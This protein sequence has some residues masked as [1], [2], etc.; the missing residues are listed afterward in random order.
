MPSARDSSSSKE[1]R[2]AAL[3]AHLQE[4]LRRRLAGQATQS[5]TIPPADRTEPLPLSFSQQRLWF[6]NEFHAGGPQPGSV[7]YNS[8]LALRL[9]GRLQVPALIAAMRELVAR[10]E[11]LRTTFD[12]VDGTGIQVVH[13]SV[14][15]PVPV[16]E[17]TGATAPTDAALDAVL[18]AEYGRPF[19]LRRG[20][21]FRALLVRIA[22]GDDGEHVLLLAAH[23]IVTDGASM[24]VLVEE[25]GALYAAAQ[26]GRQ[27]ELPPL[28]VQ[29]ADFASWQRDRLSG[30]ALAGDLDYWTRQL[31]GISRLELPVDR[32]RP[33]VR[34]S[35]G[36]VQEFTVPAEVAARLGELARA[37][38]TTLFTVL[39]AACQVL[40]ARWSGQDDIAVGTV[41]SGRNR[42]ELERLVG[43]FVNTL[44]LRAPVDRTQTFTEFLGTV[45]DT[46]LD[47]FAHQEVPFERL[48]DAV[49][50]ERDAS[51][52]PLFDVMVLLTSQQ[53]GA[54]S[55]AELRVETV[56]ISGHTAIF[57][58]TCEFQLV[59]TG[60][61]RGVWT[62]NTD[63]FDRGTVERMVEQ[64]SV[65]LAAVVTD[66]G[67]Q[68]GRLPLLAAQER[69]RVLTQWNDT[70]RVVPAATLP[71]VFAA[72]VARTPQAAAVISEAGTLS[73]PQL[74]ER[75]NRLARVLIAHGAGPER[76]VALALP[77]SVDIVVA[78]L[79]VVTA[80]A[81]FVPIDP[82][83]P[84][85]RIDFM[86]AD[87]DPVVVLT[88]AEYVGRLRRGAGNAEIVVL[89]DPD[90][91]AQLAA[92]DATAVG[93]EHRAGP[94]LL[95]HPAYVIYTSGSSGRPKAVVVTHAGL[96][97]FAAAQT[98]HFGV[99]P[100]DRV[101]QFSSPSFD[102]SV[103]ELCLAL[104][105]GAA[106]V[107]PPPGRLLAEQLADV[108]ESQRIS[109]ALIPPAALATLPPSAARELPA[110]RCLIV[111]GEA[112]L[113]ELVARWAPGRTMINAYGPTESTVVAA[114]SRPL[115]AGGP[116]PIGTPI[117]NTQL[118][119]LDQAL[120]PVPV[121]VTGELYI[122]GAGLAR[123]YLNRP[124][125]TAARFIANPFPPP[126]LPPHPH[127][128]LDADC[129]N[130][131]PDYRVLHPE[132]G[133][134]GT[135]M[136]RSGDL[137]RWNVGGWLEFVGRADEQVKI[138]GYRIELGEVESALL[139]HPD[140]AAAVV[141]LVSHDGR[142]YLLA[143][144]VAA[145]SAS[146]PTIEALREF[147]GRTLPDYMLPS[148]VT[149]LPALPLTPSGKIDRRALPTP[150]HRPALTSDYVAPGTPIQRRLADIWAEVLGGG[151][152]VGVGR[153][154]LHDN[155]FELGGDSILSLQVV[156][157][158]RQAGLRLR[159][160]DIFLH[161]TIAALAP[162][163]DTPDT[164]VEPA[165]PVDG[166]AP[167]TPIQRWFFST[168]GA[169]SHFTMSM[170]VELAE[171]LDE[172]ALQ[173]AVETVVARHDAL[174]LRF[175]QVDGQ[176]WQ[177][178]V[179]AVASGVLEHHDL[180]GLAESQQQAAV[181][182]AAAAARSDLDLG[183]GRMIRAVL[184]GRGAGQRA[185]LFL[186][187]H[188]L[189][190]DGVSWRILLDDLDTAYRQ[191]AAGAAVALDHPG[192]S[193]A[194]WAHRLAEHVES[195]ALDGELEYWTQVSRGAQADLPVDRAGGHTAGSTRRVTGR[196]GRAQTEALLH[197]VPGVYRTQINDVLLSALGRVLSGWTGRERV[198]VTL[199]GHG[200]EEILDGVDLS[201]SV[202]W[203]T[204]QFPVA[205]TVPADPDWRTVVMS[206]KEQLR[207][208]PHRGLSY[209][210]LQ[211]LSREDSPAAAL[212]CDPQPQISFNY[213]GQWDANVTADGLFRAGCDGVGADLA[214]EALT[215][216]L[217]EVTGLV[218]A[219]E[220]AL[221]WSYSEQVHDQAT[222]RRLAEEMIQALRDIV[223]HCAQP[224]AGGRTPSDFPLAHLDQAGVDR[225]VG[226]GQSI[227]D[228]H[229]LTP[230][231]AGI[232]FHSLVD[233]DSGAYVDQARLL[234]D[235]VSDPY[236]LGTAWQR[237][238]D[239]TPTLRSAVV[240]DGVDEP[241]QVVHRHAAVP[242]S[243][244]DWRGLSDVERDRELA[245]VLAADRAA[246]MDLAAPP[247]LRLAIATLAD[248]QVLLVCTSHHV[249]LDGWSL[250]QVFTEVRE[251]YAAIVADRA[252][253]LVT[254]RPFR[255]YLQW[256]GE[257]DE[258]QA[259]E[260]WRRVLSGF[261]APTGLPYDRQPLEAHRAESAETVRVELSVEESQRLQLVAKRGG[262]TLNTI[263]Q[264]VWAVLLSRYTG[265]PD[266]VFGTTVSGRPA[267]LAG[268]ESMV[269]MFINTVPTRVHVP[270]GPVPSATSP[271]TANVLS[272]LREL[273]AAQIESR[274][275][276]F[277]SLAQ[278]QACSDLPAG[279]NLFDSMVVFENYPF[280]D[281]PEGQPGLRIREVQAQD[282][283]NFPL[284][285]R[286]YLD[287]QLGVDLGYD[288]RLFD[289]ATVTAMAQ[290]LR[291]LL[292]GIAEQ[293]QRPVSELPWMTAQERHRV[294]LDWNDTAAE[295][296]AGTVVELFEAQVSRTPG[297]TAVRCGGESLSYAEL[298]AR[299]NRLARVLI[300]RGVG[301]E[302]FVALMV[303]RSVD[304]VVALWAVWKAGAAYLPIDPGYPAERIAFMFSDARPVLVVTTSEV[305]NRLPDAGQAIARLRLDDAEVTAATGADSNGADLTDADR[306][307][308]L[309][310]A[311]AA[312]LIYTSGSTGRPKGVVVA[313]R[314][315]VDLAV[316]A[317]SDFG[318]A[319]LSRVVAS[320]SLNFDVSVFEIFCPLTVG[321]C[322]EMVRDVL[323]LAESR[324]DA[325]VA[326]LISGVPSALS[327]V[328][329]Q[330]RV[331]A[332][333]VV[334]AGEALSARAVREIGSATSCR[335]IANIYGPTEA[336][337][338]ATAWYG[339]VGSSDGDAAGGDQAPPI[340]RPIANTQV[341]VLDAGLRPVPIGVPGELYLAGHGLARGYLDRPG[342]TAQRFVAN[343]FGA[344]G[345]RMYRTG[346]VVRW[347]AAGELEY[348]GRVDHQVK[349]RGFRIELGEI[350]AVLAGHPDVAQ[351][352]VIARKEASAETT[353]SGSQRLVAYLVASGP[354]T[355][356]TA[357]LRSFLGALLPDYMVPAA[358][359]VLAE[360]PLN[361]S[362]K[363]DRRALPAPEWGGGD[364][365]AHVAPRT[366]AERV[367]A[368]IWAEVL[369]VEHVGVE[370]NFFEL[371]GDSILSIRVASRLRAAFDVEL[372]PRAVFT[373]S[374]VGELAAAIPAGAGGVS[375][376][377][378]VRRDGEPAPF[379]AQ[380]SFA[381]QRLWF[382][383]EFEPDSAEYATRV[384]L[385]LR[386]ELDLDALGA[387]FTGL[388]A[389]HESLRTTFE[390][391]DGR[392]MQVVHPPHQVSLPVLDLSGLAQ[393]QL[394][395][396]QRAAE[397]DRV[398]A[399]ESSRPF[400]LS[401]GPLMR[402]RLVRLGAQD[403][404]L[405]LVLHHIITDG[406]SM[407]VLVEELSALY[408]A[409][410]RHE[411]AD[412]APL[413]VQYADF[414]AWQ[415]AA[416][417]GPVLDE[418]LAYWRGQL[419]GVPPLELPTDRPRPAIRTSAGA[420][421]EFVVSAEVTAG[422]KELGRQQDGTLF[423]TL[424][425]ACQ[426]LFSRWSGQDDIAVGTVVSGRERTELEGLIGFF[427]NTLVLRSR[428]DSS[429]S[430]TQF[431]SGVR[432]T[433]L[434]ALAHQDVP[435]ERLVD[436]LAPVRDTSRPPLF[437]AMVILQNNGNQAPD[438]PGLQ[439]EDLALPMT[440]ASFDITLE[441]QERDDVLFGA[442]QYNTDLFDAATV[443]AMAQRFVVLLAGIAAD[444][445]CAVSGLPW[446]SAD[447][448]HRVLVEWNGGMGEEPGVTL[449]E[450]F[451]SQVVR[452]PLAVA[453]RC[454]D[455]DLSYGELNARANRLAR[456]LV[457]RG[458]G[459]ERLVAL[460]LPRSLE[461]VVAI[462]AVLKAGAG[463]LPLDPDLPA[464][465]IGRIVRDADP[466]L[467]ITTNGVLVGLPAVGDAVPVL[468]LDAVADAAV[469]ARQPAGDLTD[470]QRLGCVSPVNVAYAIYTSGSTGVPKGVVVSHRN[471]VRLFSA[472]RPWFEFDERDVWTLFHSY[473]FDV[474]VWEIWGALLHGGRLVVVPFAVSRSPEEFL[475][476]LVA[477]R[478]TVLS[479]TPSA[480]YPLLRADGEHPELGAQTT[481]RYVVF[482]GE[483]L[484][485]WR[486]AP[487]YERHSDTAPVLV[488]MYG[489][490]ETTVHTTYLA[491]DAVTAAE[492]TASLIGVGIP[493]LRVYVLDARLCPVP[494]GVVGEMYVGGAA[495]T[496][497]YLN[498]PG[499]T[500]QRFV[501]DPFGAPGTRMYR[502]GDLARW[503]RDG[504][505]EFLGRADH[506]VKIRGF[507]IEPGEIEAVLVGHP[508]VAQ[509]VVIA[510]ETASTE[511]DGSGGQRLVAYVVTAGSDTHPT[512]ELRSF[513]S[514]RLPD[515]MVPAAFVLLPELP[516][517]ANGKLDRRA[518]PA[519]EW[520]AG[521]TAEYIAPRTEAEHT[522]AGI[523][524]QVLGVER[525]GVT[526]N[527]F[528]LGGDSILSIQV[529]SRVRVVFGVE[530][531]PRVLF[532]DPTV[533]G[534]AVAVAESVVSA[535]ASIGVVD[536]VGELPLSF[537]QSFAQQ[538][539]WFLDEF[540]PGGSG[541]VSAFA[542]RLCGGLDVGALSVALTGLVARHESLRTTFGAVDGRGV[543]VVHPPSVVSLPVVDLSGLVEGE[544]DAE[545]RR[546]VGL[547][548]GRGFDLGRGPLLRVLLVRVGA[549]E[550][551]LSVA[552][553]HIVTD[554]W[555]MGVLLG[556][557][558]V[559]YSAGVRG[560]DAEL[561]V[562]GVQYVD[563]AVWQRELLSGPVL[564]TALGYWREQLAGV[565]ALELPTDR[566]RPA[567]LTSAGAVCEFVV[568]AGVLAGL[569]GLG[570][571]VDG[572]LFMTLVAACQVL[573]S[574]W[575][576][577]ADIAVGTVV[578][579]R[580]RA[581]LEGLIGFFVNTVVLRFRV[582]GQ[583]SFLEFLA[584]V[585]E[586]VLDAFVHQHVPF[587][588]VV[589]EL[590]PV[591][592]TSRTPLFQAMVV[593]QNAPGH[594]T[595]LAGLEVS[596]LDLPVTTTN[597]DVTVQ[598]H[599]SG[600][601]LYGALQYNTDL[602]D[603]ATMARM[604][605]HLVVLLTGIAADPDRP[606]WGLPVLTDTETH[607]VLVGW[608][609]THREVAG[610]G[611][612]ELFEA[613]VAA[614]PEA[615]AVRAGAV[616]L[617][618]AQ[619]DERANR[620][621]HWLIGVG[622]GPERLVAVALP[623][624]V[625]LV[626]VLLAV[627]K[628]GGGYLPVDPDYPQ[629]RIAF[630][631]ADSAPV[632]VLTCAAVG[633]QVPVSAGAVRVVIDDPVVAA[634]VAA[635]PG[636][637]PTDADR[638]S[639]LALSHPAYVIYTSGSTGRPKAVVVT[640]AGLSSFSAAEI[641]HYRVGPG[642][643]VLAM[644]SPSFD[645]S[646]LELGISLLAG[647]VWVLPSVAGP[648]AGD[649]L[650][651]VLA[652]DRISHALIPPAALATLPAQVAE[653]GLPEFTTVIVGGDVCSAEL[654]T[655]WAPNRR[656]INSYGPTE[657]TVVA[658]W[659]APLVAGPT[660]PV[661]G[662]P[663]PNTRIYVLDRWLR[664]VPVGVTG[665][666]Y[667]AG[668][669]LARGY[670]HR[671]GLTAARFVATPYGAPGERMYRSGDL[672]R[673]TPH[674]QLDYLGRADQQI[675]IR[676]FRIEPGEIEAVLATHPT[677]S[678]VAVTAHQDQPGTTRLVAYV[679]P[680]GEI[681]ATATELRTHTAGF[682][683]DYMIPTI[684]ITLDQIP[685]TA[686]GKLDRK[687][688]PTPD[689]HTQPATEH[690]PPRTPTEHTLAD[691]WAQ[692]LG[693]ERV[694]VTDNFF[695]LGG[696]SILSIQVMSRVRVVFGVELSPRVL[697]V[698]PT[699]GGLAVAVAES[700]VSASA[701]IG[702]VDRVGELPLS[703]VQS[704]AQQRLWFLDEFAPGG[705][706]YV[707]AFALRL[708]GGLDVG[709][710]SVAL[711]GLVA[712]HESLR[713]TFGAVDGRGV[714][715][716][717][718]PS[719][720]SLP[721][722]DLSGLVEGERDAELRRVV[723]LEAGRGFDLGRGPL[724]RVLLVRV[725]AGEHVLSVAMHHIVTDGWS[726]G[727]LLGELG[728]LYS[729]G[730][731]GQDAELPVLGVQYV[732][733]AVW[734]R[735]LLS[736]PV[737]DTALG[738]WR[739]QLA[740]VPALELPTDR[741]RPAVL[742]SAG[743]VCEFVVPAGVLAGLTGL[744]R[745][746]DGT[747]FMTLVAAC[748]VLFSRWSG[749]ADIAVGTVVSG[750]ERAELEGLIGFFVNTVV[751]RF[752]V[753][754]QRSFLEF[755]AG[756]R[757]TVLDAFVHQHVPFERVVDELAPVRDTSRT[758]LFQAMVVLQNAPGHVT[759]LAG[760]EVS[761]LD[762]PVTTTNFDVT[763]QFHESGG[764]LYG[765]LQ[766]NTDLFDAATMA[767]MADHL[768]V[769]LTGI[770]AD[771]DRPVWGLPVL[772]DTETHQVLVGWNDTHREVA[773]AGLAELFEARVAAR[774]EAQA[775]RAGA[776]SLSYA[777][778]DERAN[779]L[780][781]WLIGVGV[782]P[783]RLVAV[784][785]PRS[786]ELVV[787]LLAVAKAGGGY[788]P[789]DPDYPQQRIAFM[790]ADSAPVVVL[791][792]A[793]VGPQVPVSAGAV[794]VVI[795]DPVVAAEVAAMPGHSPTD[796]DRLSVLA[797]S[798]PAYVIYTSGSTGRPKAVVV[799][800]AGLSSFSAAEIEH[801]R[802]GPGDR[803]LAMSSPSFDAS[804]LELGISLLAGAVWVLPSVAGPL[805]GD[806][807]LAVL[808]HDRISHALIPPAALATL[809][810]Q[811][812]E[813]G[814]PEFTTVIVGG[815]V[816]SAELVTRWAPNRRMI[817]SYGPTETTVVACWSAPLVAGPTRPVI[818]SPIP[819]T[820]I[821][822][823]DRWLRPVPV[824]V[825]GELYIAGVGL[826]RGYLHR[827]GLTAARFVATPY[828]APGERMYRSG[829]LARWTPH[830]QLDYLGR[831]DQ[832]IKIRG[833]R[834]E[835][836]E[837]EA[838]LATHP[839][840]SEVAVT[841]HQDQP[842]TT[843]L[844]A[845]VVP[846]GEIVATATELRT[847]T[848]GFLPDY[849]IPTIFITLDQIPLTANGKLDR[850][851]LPTPD[852]HTQPTTEHIPPRTPTEH[853]LTDI[854][855]QVLGIEQVGVTDNFFE[856]GGDS[857]LSIQVVSRARRA[858]VSV[859]TKDIFFRQ[860]VAELAACAEVAP[861]SGSVRGDAVAGPAPLMPIQRW[862]F[863]TYG[864]L[865]H[866]NQSVVAEL[867][868]D[869]DEA[870][871]S[872]SVDALVAH[873]PALRM[874]FSSVEGGWCQEV[875][876]AETG[877]VLHRYDL[878]D[879]D[880]EDQRSAMGEAAVAA[881]SSLDITNGP[882]LAAVLFDFGPGRRS[883]LFITI[884]HL[885]VDGVSWRILLEDLEAA[886]HQA[887][888]GGPV[889]LE[890]VGTPFTQWAHRLTE[891]VQAGE[892]DG[893]VEYWSE[894]PQDALPD[895]P[896]ARAG[897]NTAD[898]SRVVAVRLG[899]DDTDALL[900]RVPGIYRTQINDVLLSALGR[901]LSTWTGRDRVLVA[902]EGHGREE[903]LEGADLSRTV[904]WFTSQFPVALTVCSAD[905]GELL[906]FV[907]EQVR[908]I[909]HR[910][911]SYG[912]LRY[913]RPGG[914]SPQGPAEGVLGTDAQPQI[915]LNYHGQT[916]VAADSGGLY[917]G[918]PG[919]LAPD[920]AP[921]SIRTYLLD[922]T[923]VVA[924][925][926]LELSW[927][928]SENVHDEATIARLAS[929][930]LAALQEIVAHC[931][932]PDV[933]GCTPSDFPL[934]RL[935]QR[936]LDHVVGDGRSVEDVY[937]LTPLQAG[938]VFHSLLDADADAAAYVDQIRM[939]L[940]GVGD[941][942][943]LGVA[944]QRVV[945]RT[946]LL[947]SAVVWAGVD[948]PVQ[949]VQRE[950]VLPVTHYD[951]RDL[952]ELDRDRELARVA[953]LE[954][955]GVDLS[956]PPLLRMVIARLSDDEVLLVWTHHH[957]VL[958]GWSMAAVFAEVCEQYAAIVQGRAPAQ[959]ARRPFRDYLGWLG[960][961]DGGHA[962]EHWR[963]A[964]SGFDSRTPLPY[965]RPPLEAHRS[966]SSESVYPQLG[967][968][969]S[970]RLQQVAKRN[971]L[972]VNTIVQ[973]A[974]ALLL[975]RYSG[976]RD[977]VFGTTVSG[978]P[979]ELPGVESMVGMFINTVPTRASVHDGQEVLSWLRELQ[980]AQIESRRFDFVSLAQLQ[981][982]SDLPAGSTL[983]D[984][985]V[986]FENYPF[987]SESVTGAG[988][989]VHELQARETTNFPLTLQA[990]LGDRLGLRL[991]YD[992][993]LFDAA[994]AERMAEHLLVLLTGIATNPDRPV[995]QLPL[996][997]AAQTHQ[998]V[999][1000][1001]N[1002]TAREAPG[1003]SLPE[1004]FAAQV[1005]DRLDAEAVRAGAVSLSYA[1006]LDEQANRWAHWLIELG[1007][1008]PE[1009]LVAVALPRSVELV[1010]AL[1011][1012][1013][1014]K[1015]GGGYLPIDP[1016]YPEDRIGFMLTDAAPVVVLTCTSVAQRVPVFP[1017]AARV[1018]IDDPVVVAEVATMSGN[1019]PTDADRLCA[1020]A[1021][1022]HPAY[1023]IYTSG[1024]TG[1025]PKA[1026]VVTHAGLR[1027]FTEAEI[1028]H[1029]QVS[1030]G[1031]R[1032]LAMSS[1033][1034]FDASVLELGISLLAGA[1035]WVFAPTPGPLAGE[1036]L[1037]AVLEQEGIS[1038]ALIPP[1039]ALA[1040]IPA[1041]VAAG[1042][1043]PEWGTVI[1044]GGD[1045]C[1046]AELVRRWAPGRR[1047]I[1048]SYGPTEATVV[1049]C[1050]TPPLVPG[1051]DRP[1052]IGCPIPNTRIY[1053][1054]DAWLRPVPVGVAGELYIAGIGLARGYLNRAGLTAAR[1055]VAN[1056]FGVPGER[1057]Y[1058]SGDLACW[1059]PQGQL[1060][1061]LGR[1062]DE[1063][1064]KIRGFRIEPG[1065]IEA[1066]LAAHPGIHDAVVIARED[1067]PG[1068]KRL[1069]GYVV[1070]AAEVTPSAAQLSP[1071]QL[1072]PAQL[1073]AHL[1074]LALP[1075]YMVPAVFV[1076]L[1077]E[1078][1079]L[1080]PNGKVDRK[1081]L[1082]APDRG[1083]EPVSE[1084]IAARSATEHTLT[1085]IWAQVLGVER[1086]GV[1087]D[1088]FFELGG[1089]SILSIQVMS[1090]VRV[1091]FEVEL[1092]PRVL[1093]VDPTVAGLAVAVAE[1094][1095]VSASASIDVVDRTAELPLS[1096]AQQ[1097]LW[1098][1099]D[1100]FEPGGSGYVSAF[1101]LRL[1102]GELDL[1103]A[1104][1105]VALSALVARHESL[1106]TTFEAVDGRGVQVVRPPYEVALPV[1107]DLSDVPEYERAAELR[1108]VVGLETSRGFDLGRGPLLRAGVI[1109]VAA[1110]E[1111][1112]VTLAMHHI[1113]TDGWSMGVLVA[1114][1115]GVLYS[1116]VACGQDA[1117]LPV[1118]G[1119]QYVDYAVW[1120]RELLSGPVLDTALGYW[1121]EQLAG[1122][1123]A[1124]EL[1125]TD[1126]PRPAVLTS[1127]GAVCEFVVPAQVLA[1128]LTGLGH[1129][1130]DGTLFMTLVAACQVLFSRWSGQAD[1131][1132]V[1133]TVVSGRERAELEGLIGFFVNTVV[1134]RSQV[1135]G[1136]R[1137]FLEFL[1138]GVRETV[1139]D[1140]FVHQ[1141]VPFER[1142]VD[1143]LAPVRDTSRT[1144]L[1145]QAMV[1146]LQNAPGQAPELAGLEV[1147]GLELP[1148]STA[1149]FDITVQFQESGDELFGALQYNT[1150]LFDAATVEAMAQRFVVLLAGIAADPDCAVSGLPWMS[1151]DERH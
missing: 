349:I 633:P 808:A 868:E 514:E 1068:I 32:P 869:L 711:T 58:L 391:V 814:L 105:A 1034:S 941:T 625:E 478:V 1107:L 990:A 116:A 907:K 950:V 701:S 1016:D 693:V 596:G 24:G 346:D 233:P 702:V 749:Q 1001:W 234:L 944:W 772:T 137:V 920:H 569:T 895:L 791:T 277:V 635:M 922:V 971:G 801:Y 663:I 867:A 952:A 965:D 587:E 273:Q 1106:R 452:A 286:A 1097:R 842:G 903:I 352:V 271:D 526:D 890:P 840:I 559:L 785:L 508:D 671:P 124:A 141:R 769:L 55:F 953:A 850:K 787:V 2:I 26:R 654:V 363:L 692:V 314:S 918:W 389:R 68:V 966:E 957:V 443:E 969:D 739:E 184:F 153:I 297:A 35:A 257:Q 1087:T 997:T 372:S 685:L 561:P 830:G 462:V 622:V 1038:H 240:W 976:A 169:L 72:A 777:Q 334:L 469:I 1138:A 310:G 851:A 873:H 1124:L 548:A 247:L 428:V 978:R 807:L 117:A 770:A 1135:E 1044:V 267:E 532:V 764:L 859:T 588:R 223:E 172:N 136:Y 1002:D 579:G 332:D 986:V 422:L 871:L 475:R 459:P 163:V 501:A 427:V 722:V 631:L 176:W 904:G 793:A 322:I 689:Q 220:L 196:L 964:L 758:P 454:G 221:T 358:F 521:A 794:R 1059:T 231:Q 21:L 720:V 237:M 678:E 125:L 541:Y 3:P 14:E 300:G 161:Q 695:E 159:S 51:H 932:R 219:G 650:L 206:V 199:E 451:E 1129:R 970:A 492:A 858:G 399:A 822:V 249:V 643:R 214:P 1053:V 972:T 279:V 602:F 636:H 1093:F 750:R 390:Q 456:C 190:V 601:L 114:W 130:S 186:A 1055:F 647:A 188:H 515:Y 10:H 651:A 506:Q 537:V 610:A 687:A 1050:W 110:F 192:T 305:E 852:Q 1005:A 640:H 246:G 719:V 854:W 331:P 99:R 558:G 255:D 951:W 760:L 1004:L 1067:L 988:L 884:H 103:L 1116:A 984:S 393:P 453:V 925:G 145:G 766:Y 626:V 538:R 888:G 222:M 815:D 1073:R 291:L 645:A 1091:A 796:A 112:C 690:I 123:G 533:G 726:M 1:S 287:R 215:P 552:M 61:L 483:A 502:S 974:W 1095:V 329:S 833:F 556:E 436:E 362:G 623:R 928:Y 498:R 809:P 388:V 316:W 387:A 717:H 408:R 789:V 1104:L 364:T 23:H 745:R 373:H 1125:P 564:D 36:A 513:L 260:H 616:S 742:T 414:A 698:D 712:R 88:H 306:A 691:I 1136:Q 823:L 73:Y 374:T 629:Q 804:V 824:G 43:F 527:F 604:A 146:A 500:S 48:V 1069:V 975:S 954:R 1025:R 843:R 80:G 446:M 8:G 637:S 729:A 503:N 580:E 1060:E 992:P 696:D 756:V 1147:S 275:F 1029:Y 846:A 178:A 29:Y 1103:N 353:G 229:P 1102:R 945:E 317:R 360:L 1061:Y 620:L 927:T 1082:P 857:I 599:E 1151:A 943:A 1117:Q 201:R 516:L 1096:F 415:R 771:P 994:T 41:V 845:Y 668:V 991:G 350:E 155:F 243:Y 225:L 826:A 706:G 1118:L 1070:P 1132:A 606:V 77:R 866:F 995:Q 152:G 203:F 165:P 731:R 646:V 863:A 841:A 405:I 911:L 788:L 617:S 345:A 581:E 1042:G 149:V 366:E 955:A 86:L 142:P 181:E 282:T 1007:V 430:F 1019:S 575:S 1137:S 412:L 672:A 400:D 836:G 302:R 504:G 318:A 401:R 1088:N 439:I 655:R 171:N 307:V 813:S 490:T 416:L 1009:R 368:G 22:D 870:A 481:L 264:G 583:R 612:A 11:S 773:G 1062:A 1115:L 217:V 242:T 309:S 1126:R 1083:A 474:S 417:T 798:H 193:A 968:Q 238:V 213:H 250:A 942:Q 577:Q 421:H 147:A 828:G 979:A 338:Y 274:R 120:Q 786:V 987:D 554:G 649:S 998:V 418:G 447:E 1022:S 638:L 343:P 913:L 1085:D 982:W 894:L 46:V 592:D 594:V 289:A 200:R 754:G 170:L 295:V 292:T 313:A 107:V 335:R 280:E 1094:S 344:P 19:D 281:P 380:Q 924:N 189:A 324:V 90:W 495:V 605:D 751:L 168:Y 819:N 662:S 173:A 308:P 104:P 208:V 333:T 1149:N 31:S 224:G 1108:R 977:V 403:H 119:V 101:L 126:T 542:L 448:R 1043:L 357:E 16:V 661:I 211:Q 102:A 191:A 44:V 699:V 958:D 1037:L 1141:H 355:P 1045:V 590:A 435:F 1076:V 406:W 85:G 669:G 732:D 644:S 122:A 893:D 543:Q 175:E 1064:V 874:R 545:L 724:L 425:A 657:T 518:L 167:L 375:V 207:A 442:L 900:H 356:T 1092:S 241:L 128:V 378:V 761:G 429:R 460:A 688:L 585:R 84:G 912:A 747:L 497:G 133:G 92:T 595:D 479:Q 482:A 665:E 1128:G 183:A 56:D 707:S 980:A 466:V 797:L 1150:D 1079:P 441:F 882:M 321:G 878:S 1052:P 109:H 550:H 1127:A 254:R 931:A 1021:L 494:S 351:A 848:A 148:A 256:L 803:V 607:Q 252:P 1113:V 821:Y 667:I 524:A 837:I 6:L 1026:V 653:S 555:S 1090:R 49:H 174:R 348:L 519:P 1148:V 476:L 7:Q 299:A 1139:L 1133:G 235:G 111:G 25:L 1114:E 472:T 118:Y 284:S 1048:N 54:A 216:H 228:I 507:R 1057:M 642:D 226:N 261:C 359:V 679:V 877:A 905:W 989:Q 933:G 962:E 40:F 218:E 632:V 265:Q 187:V 93:D 512:A 792:C 1040:T 910:G 76:I 684:F 820:R 197:Q 509:A 748:Q 39:V 1144:P 721:V 134:G 762:L 371:G 1013:V 879:L 369:G 1015:A 886:Y 1101:A 885:V 434:G 670:L 889:E 730:V 202:G 960:E 639:V 394:T 444:P 530:L 573:F 139:A 686:N 230:L 716:V 283:T 83:Y 505:L 5:D 710:L 553:H 855:A 18:S 66:P 270:S 45:R 138:R 1041:D 611:L 755:L 727:V 20:P 775:V 432:D 320:T 121:G 424:V 1112:V 157:R 887:R 132:R 1054:L 658:C 778:V 370:D 450:A 499:L 182:A 336:T 1036:S 385:R 13:P 586:T 899:R 675:K 736:G 700:V 382:L 166:L 1120:Q 70:G 683:P 765:A 1014:A 53:R 461:M 1130:V 9:R 829:D 763:V 1075:D 437:Q 464:E 1063:Q 463:Y 397:L 723:G 1027:S 108:L 1035:V 947:R 484:D 232:L 493:D 883:R 268:V 946:P 95:S 59:G 158:A 1020:L 901:V 898:S 340:G 1143:E 227:Q 847:H 1047:M 361:A 834:I 486:L 570:R 337:V 339:D 91:A 325:G 520:G 825:T 511:A 115:T 1078:M 593:L 589:D 849:M 1056:P 861:V 1131:I 864:P 810:A 1109:R 180:S 162:L 811:V 1018:L 528:E 897:A 1140:A 728:V 42:A 342:L 660:R 244:H 1110:A 800:H 753:E 395:E 795:D 1006:E 1080:S 812:A 87:A 523:W 827:P 799:T 531:S 1012:A 865:P 740:G 34:T 576:G 419:D 1121:R 743:A 489:I 311:H 248:D 677:I 574:R 613:R 204:T 1134:L 379:F 269:G 935:T 708:C 906:K 164:P 1023:V 759:D 468:V 682:L 47:A 60:E 1046:S 603:A 89:D 1098:F 449:V 908:A 285:L 402:P 714:Q 367:V 1071:A 413:P 63:L 999:V 143:Y 967:T 100:G 457:E 628:A 298:N 1066:V 144:L 1031:D 875:A 1099:L 185:R 154:G 790:L 407:G 377:P 113:A 973:G 872:V 1032:V 578:S 1051:P 1011:L 621:A 1089:D 694:G 259:E 839:T 330:S 835:P 909:P 1072:S 1039:A 738:Y 768:V 384:G 608:N 917:R 410:A 433:V 876:P 205:L 536:R 98:E 1123:P 1142:V 79:A 674:G 618:Y 560:Q 17:L 664:P 880:E 802:V 4:A 562:L 673:W 565:P 566:P 902:L 937:P 582:E 705:S 278:V 294:L 983:F 598:F 30:P 996:L 50:A 341:Y 470:A 831:A 949:V 1084:Y 1081:A 245:R 741:P 676:G 534:L 656:M 805:A 774:P 817:N 659:S 680:A 1030:P 1122:V 365:A 784:A 33:Q 106:M 52:N 440:T 431:L 963:A 1000:E 276:D 71:E 597:F 420:M 376:I 529:M 718:P 856:L 956:V 584:G 487:W 926:E 725:G 82:D 936:Q 816:C 615:Q 465:R 272:W 423:M 551:V 151:V 838:V 131:G 939:R 624:S 914:L 392:G 985:M 467:V 641:E 212:R 328:L 67:Q 296:P 480:F 57:D 934:A 496:R 1065:E 929:E 1119:V 1105:S 563:Y 129:G 290:R 194:T 862:F 140:I 488:N 609:D 572:T 354:S 455:E 1049:A 547:E 347:N 1100:E 458:A 1033:P 96:A 522:L 304:L 1024:S 303:P 1077:D 1028:E 301:A 198:L 12:E 930:M 473:A 923:G 634:E 704:F 239:R 195:G 703:F 383:H 896:V 411:V 539:L 715:V 783:E 948:E 386:G 1086:V 445:D 323:A 892:L 540:A 916:G 781:H 546:V 65:L 713:T 293:P 568:P 961:Q 735:E 78:Q 938:M 160:Q 426:L 627:A 746:V 288:P 326:S 779:R 591:R 510:R 1146:L 940:S 179:P 619:V 1145:F 381:Q 396:Q 156:S 64:L 544:R 37:Q 97:S 744:G 398:L 1010:V 312:Y 15:V 38:D 709:A 209:G 438:L 62:Y 832:Q 919:A 767:R 81:A 525:V 327:Q 806:S 1003:A 681:V 1074:A 517:N 28:P 600:G 571:R 135:R 319:G 127:R 549:G 921:D 959:P 666:L 1008:G 262:L 177:Q 491:L 915:C 535:S 315:V 860:T 485:L 253:E 150:E 891:H 648:L 1111:H 733:Y 881:Q 75:V 567:V 853:T 69:E 210:A 266:V 409:A 236:A 404:A 844:V 27:A 734:Q 477:E 258:R 780:A 737:L 630:M 263:V 94:L 74:A 776:V 818:G 752:R 782:G 757:E 993:K 614:R 557:L 251:Q 1058:R 471:V 1017:G 981:A 697:F 652:H